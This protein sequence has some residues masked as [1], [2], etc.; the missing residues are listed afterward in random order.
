MTLPELIPDATPLTEVAGLTAAQVK[1]L[2][3]CWITTTQEL[4]AVAAGREATRRLLAQALGVSRAG[5]P[6]IVAAARAASP[7]VRSP[8]ADPLLD[9]ALR[10]D[11][12]LGALLIEPPEVLAARRGL[13][14]Y[15][16]A[17]TRALLP[18]SHSLLHQL[19]PLRSQGP[20]GTCVPHAVLALREQLEMA[21]GAPAQINL[22]EQYVYWWCKAHD[23]VPHVSGSY[24]S[25]GMRCLETVGAPLEEVWPYNRL[26]TADP[27]QGP[28]PLAAEAGDAAFRTRRTLEFNR[29][30]INGIKTCLHENR[31]VV[32]SAP[33][34]DSWYK[35]AACLA[36][37][38]ITLPLPGEAYNGGHAMTLVGYQDDATAPGGG[39]FLVRNSWQPWA[40]H[41][42]WQSGYG[43]IPYAYITGYAS[44]IYSAER[45][46][47]S[48][49]FV[50]GAPVSTDPGLIAAMGDVWLRRAPDGGAEMQTPQPGSENALYVRVTQPG[51]AH[52]YGL[53]GEIFF[54]R[55]GLGAASPWQ[56]AGSFAAAWL[57]PGANVVGPIA[58]TPAEGA[59]VA[60]AVRLDSGRAG[61]LLAAS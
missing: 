24:L 20:R 60:F 5:L 27:G 9:E 52:A 1:L 17:G 56:P 3:D 34:Y 51:P 36:W 8:A 46:E 19:P 37:G 26:K 50:R 13:P 16:P 45:V 41:G 18:A 59:A 30:D 25:V 57:R 12:G 21:A 33:V 32:F 14:P 58:W 15:Q 53:T 43:Y 42:V 11:F 49:P 55:A 61:E 48:L 22:S 40:W 28:P 44:A 29:A 39:Y 54:K 4:I 38:K 10:T 7:A 6:D 2:A 47:G 35:S 31:A 23:G